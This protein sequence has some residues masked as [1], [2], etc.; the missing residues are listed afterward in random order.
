M[1]PTKLK[2]LT[3]KELNA[4]VQRWK[5]NGEKIVF[6]NGCFD[7]LH[8]GH[9]D[10]LEKA[11]ILGDKLIVGVNSDA[12][13]KR[14]K[15]DNRPVVNEQSRLR[16]IAS[17][18]FVDGV[19]SFDEDTPQ[20]LIEEIIP[21]ILVKG[22]DYEISNIVGSDI[23]LENGGKVETIELVDGYSTTAIIEKIKKL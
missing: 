11:S 9:I 8:L 15:G 20:Q 7:I 10:Y 1:I 22:K 18:E 5:S 6:T 17:L 21:D 13:I 16:T 14:I 4:L 3:K 19:V 12:S 2:I 23:V